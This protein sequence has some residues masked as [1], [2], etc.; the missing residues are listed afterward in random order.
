MKN[1]SIP[2]FIHILNIHNLHMR[3]FQQCDT[4]LCMN[5]FSFQTFGFNIYNKE[6]L[7][8]GRRA[9]VANS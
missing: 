1:F 9:E 5:N 6:I 4:V 3:L 8:L 2:L 7:F